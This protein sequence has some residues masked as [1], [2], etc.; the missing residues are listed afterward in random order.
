MLCPKFTDCR[1][2][3]QVFLSW[4]L[5]LERGLCWLLL[6]GW[7]QEACCCPV[8]QSCPTLRDPMHCSTPVFPVLHYRPEFAQ[9]HVHW[10]DDAIQP[11]SSSLVP[12][13][14]YLQSFPASGSFS[15]SW[16]FASGGQSIGASGSAW[17][18]S[19]NIQHWL[20]LG[21]TSLI[22]LTPAV[23][24]PRLLQINNKEGVHS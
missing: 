19:M 16:L 13:S 15:M 18:L 23:K 21:L 11:I 2:P 5:S 17:V 4:P 1:W 12:F 6:S 9:T 20:P 10:V 8:A 7:C 22:S 24:R 3:I 14:S